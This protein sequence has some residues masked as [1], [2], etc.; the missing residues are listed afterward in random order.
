MKNELFGTDGIR[1]QVGVFP[2]D[3]ASTVKLG[4]ILGILFRNSRILIGRD[5]RESSEFVENLLCRGLSGQVKI[6]SIGIIPTPGLSLLTR[7][8]GF[9]SGIMIS[10]S[11]NLYTDNGIKIFDR[12]GEKIPEKIEKQIEQLFR[13]TLRSVSQTPRITPCDR[14]GEYR[15]FLLENGSGIGNG[16]FKIVIDCA[17]G[18][19]SQY[20][21]EVF[22]KLGFDVLPIHW[23]PNGR[24][25]NAQCGS[26]SPESLREKVLRERADL[27]I[28]FD[29]DADRVIYVDSLGRILDG[30]HSIFAIARLLAETETKFNR[31]VVGTVMDNLGLEKALA[32]RGD[33]DT[34]GFRR[35]RSIRGYRGR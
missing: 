5:T 12:T 28:A 3:E 10:A 1:S 6:F 15:R 29:G 20:G 8:L 25:I 11:H 35:I 21:P 7:T 30:E 31:V 4:N 32:G 14:S 18:A 17:N 19:A 27:G 22:G 23:R 33:R 2:L 16:R 24:N 34:G 26:T 9:D 13:I